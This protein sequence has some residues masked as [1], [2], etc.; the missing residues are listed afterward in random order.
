ME[1]Y[2]YDKERDLLGIVEA[3]EYLRWTRKYSRCGSFE[4]KALA[5]D[6]NLKLLK[7]NHMLWKNDDEEIGIIEFLELTMLEQ[8]YIVVS[9]RFATSLLS[10]RIIWGIEI[11]TRDISA[12]V[13]A[14]I[15]NHLISPTFSDR[16]IGLAIILA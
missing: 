1:L 15:T 7:I 14:L 4:L 13:E 9:G 11:L 6:E 10:R 3:F 2:I 8:E 5:T 12:G 16:V